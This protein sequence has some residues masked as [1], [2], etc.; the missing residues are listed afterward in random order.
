[1]TLR[2]RTPTRDHD[3]RMHLGVILMALQMISRPPTT[4][5]TP[6]QLELVN[7]IR[8]AAKAMEAL[9]DKPESGAKRK[10]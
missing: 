4:P 7:V 1:M 10:S 8:R 5:L 6:S 9:L 3:L 2:R